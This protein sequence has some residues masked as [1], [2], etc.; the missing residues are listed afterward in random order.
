MGSWCLL[1]ILPPILVHVYLAAVSKTALDGYGNLTF[2]YYL[3][4]SHSERIPPRMDQGQLQVKFLSRIYKKPLNPFM[5]MIVKYHPVFTTGAG[6][7][8]DCLSEVN[9][10]AYNKQLRGKKEILAMIHTTN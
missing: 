6:V 2:L 4:L 8:D 10:I 1:L 5:H 7:A 3:L 9:S